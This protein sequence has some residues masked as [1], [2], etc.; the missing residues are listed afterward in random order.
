[1]AAGYKSC[2]V[3]TWYLG[4]VLSVLA[5]TSAMADRAFPYTWTSTTQA[6]KTTDAE[7]WV[8]V[9][10]GRPTP[11]DLL[12]V[13]GWASAGVSKRVDVHF[14]LEAEVLMLRREQRT[15]D[16]RV[17]ALARYRLFDPDDV[18]GVALLA[19]AGFGVASAVLEGRLVLDRKLGDVW[20]ALN[21]SYE[22]TV[23]WDRREAIDTRL[24]HSFAARLLVTPEVSA[25]FE[26]RGRQAFLSGAYQGTALYVGPTLSISTKWVWFSVG[27]VA[28]V[29]A[30]KIQA[31]RGNGEHVIFRDDERFSLRLI[32][33][34]PTAK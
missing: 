27:A 10:S 8:S 5:A 4:S 9:R 26:V 12:E 21:S 14:G 20:L 16:G 15:F 30:D 17:S 11:Y 3:R 28:Q 29:G 6:N 18:L 13:R 23:F 25:G 22:R 19:R 7:L 33:G 34:A 1:M 31:D 24:E 32:V 2:A